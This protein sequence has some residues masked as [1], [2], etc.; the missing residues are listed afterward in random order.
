MYDEEDIADVVSAVQTGDI[1]VLIEL[2]EKGMIS[3][4]TIDKD[5]CSL[6]HWAAINNRCEIAKYLLNHGADVNAIG[7]ILQETPLAWAI[8]KSF[9]QMCCILLQAGSKVGLCSKNNFTVLH[10]AFKTGRYSAL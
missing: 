4:T 9:V 7:G 1:E 5:G 6:L 3:V 10:L 2:V 8:R